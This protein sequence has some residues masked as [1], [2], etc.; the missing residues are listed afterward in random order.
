MDWLLLKI[1]NFVDKTDKTKSEPN[2]KGVAFGVITTTPPTT[3]VEDMLTKLTANLAAI[4]SDDAQTAPR[5]PHKFKKTTTSVTSKARS[6][7]DGPPPYPCK[8][9]LG[10]E[11]HWRGA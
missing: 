4:T 5:G 3:N 8:Y 2:D 10:E 7:F 6:K 11:L 1:K 9:C